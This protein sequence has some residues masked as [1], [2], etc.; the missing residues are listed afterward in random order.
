MT[1]HHDD[2]HDQEKRLMELLAGRMDPGSSEARELLER[3]PELR[4][5]FEEVCKLSGV[6]DEMGNREKEMVRTL[7]AE[8]PSSPLVDRTLHRIW[9]EEDQVGKQP[10]SKRPWVVLSVAGLAAAA[11][12]ILLFTFWDRAEDSGRGAP[13]LLGEPIEVYTTAYEV[14]RYRFAWEDMH[15]GPRGEYRLY[16]KGA[17]DEDKILMWHG[18]ATSWIPTDEEE[19]ALPSPLTWWVEANYGPVAF[20]QDPDFESPPICQVRRQH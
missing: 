8:P 1:S 6:L 17:G 14:D 10:A 11:A 20:S 15:L 5:A 18:S 9:K 13:Y 3:D 12:L 19:K 2:A 7:P 16:R 4:E